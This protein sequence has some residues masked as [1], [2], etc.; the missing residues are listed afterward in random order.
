ML[1]QEQLDVLYVCI[2]PFCHGDIEE[3][4]TA[5]GI[6]L[7]VEKP[8]GLDV[9]SVRHKAKVISESGIIA[10][11]GYCLR[12]LDTVAIAKDFLKD[13][14]RNGSRPL[15]NNTCTDSLV[16]QEGIIRRATGGAVHAYHGLGSL[17]VRR[18]H[19]PVCRY[20]VPLVNDI[21]DLDI[22]D[23]GAIQFVLDSG[24]V[25]H[26]QT[27]FIQFDHRAESRSWVATSA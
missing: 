21:P 6:H 5:K 13:K 26:M 10:T 9:Q 7:M 23:V 1:E 3:Q 11:S 19:P 17:S 25:G 27:G 4:A 22:P 20:E 14:N 24:A 2:P 16:A 15:H 18:Y 8:L 12:Y